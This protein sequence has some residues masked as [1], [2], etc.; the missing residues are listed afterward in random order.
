MTAPAVLTPEQLLTLDEACETLLQGKVKAATL[1]AAIKRGE[2]VPERL[3]R[4]RFVTPAIIAEWRARCRRSQ[5]RPASGSDQREASDRPHGSSST[6]ASNTPHDVALM[7]VRALKESLRST[8][9]A[10]TSREARGI[11]AVS[12]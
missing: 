11:R 4:Q 7:T 8:S 12:R 5:S 9:R 1:E 10:N 2:L 3:G 6:S